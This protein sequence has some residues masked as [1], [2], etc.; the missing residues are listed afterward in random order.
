M[1]QKEMSDVGKNKITTAP[2]Y[3]FPSEKLFISSSRQF[4]AA[5]PY[6]PKDLAPPHLPATSYT[7][8]QPANSQPATSP[9]VTTQTTPPSQ[10]NGHHPHC[11][12]HIQ[13][14]PA[15]RTINSLPRKFARKESWIFMGY[16][17]SQNTSFVFVRTA[18][19][20]SAHP[21]TINH[22]S[23]LYRFFF[24]FKFFPFFNSFFLIT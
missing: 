13:H 20:R 4:L 22:W 1:K 8:I 3:F 18:C 16:G 15:D 14:T 6:C 5:L 11:T 9:Y 24:L 23:Y 7:S 17:L 19:R 21:R 2:F 10:H 12:W